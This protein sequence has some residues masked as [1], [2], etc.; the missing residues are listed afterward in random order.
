MTQIKTKLTGVPRTMLM[1]TRARV[2]E[3]QREI[4][5][6]FCDP[7]VFEWW[8]AIAWDTDLDRFYQPLSQLSWAVRANAF[9]QV[10]R[11]HI[12]SYA[13]AVVVE[14]GAGLSTRYYRVG[15]GCKCWIDLDLPQVTTL[16]RQ[17]DSE[18]EQHR[19]ISRSALDFDWMDELPNC[20]SEHLLIIA[21]GLLMYFTV[22]QVQQLIY[23][24]RQRF[25]NATFMFDV[26]GGVSKGKAAKWLAE[27]GAPMQ[28]FVKN[29]RD[30]DG[31]GLAIAQVLSLMQENYRYPHRLNALRW[32][33][34][35]AKLP[36]FRNAGLILETKVLPLSSS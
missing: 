26:V 16:R 19:F 7:K 10:A 36:Y 23:Q 14:L 32:I 15:R 4:G 27:L 8:Q 13:D 24:L 1:T 9:D 3:H 17:L 30:I 35:I 22:E 33:P 12:T 28:W 20:P 18:T 31:M 5:A 25:P 21:E 29:E 34:W 2:D 11:R 6:L